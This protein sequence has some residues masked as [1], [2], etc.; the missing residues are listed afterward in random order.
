MTRVY[1]DRGG[2]TE[3]LKNRVCHVGGE[4]YHRPVWVRG[5]SD[6][7]YNWRSECGAINPTVHEY[8][9][10]V[11]VPLSMVKAVLRPCKRC[12]PERKDDD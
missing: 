4:C 10:V 12:F 3:Y 8:D 7:T 2:R 5:D 11:V 6:N 1:K 9:N